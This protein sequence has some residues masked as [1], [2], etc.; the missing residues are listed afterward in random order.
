MN[1]ETPTT[2][3][4]R[5]P[6]GRRGRVAVLVALLI[7]ALTMLGACTSNSV[8]V[9]VDGRPVLTTTELDQMAAAFE[10][11][12]IE[13]TREGILTVL[14]YK[15][16]AEQ[17]AAERGVELTDEVR[18]QIQQTVGEQSNPTVEDLLIAQEEAG[19]LFGVMEEQQAGLAEQVLAGAD[20]SVNPRYGTWASTA[21]G[22]G[23]LTPQGLAEP[24]AV[25]EN[26]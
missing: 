15:E 17:A 21:Q 3:A 11:S 2:A 22:Y 12:E 19:A 9:Y 24:A 14:I 16:I 4:A 26:G 7:G 23:V 25:E 18:A 6:S 20:V 1:A 13:A 10:G 5:R 8:A